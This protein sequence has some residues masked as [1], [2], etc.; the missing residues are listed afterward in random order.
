MMMIMIMIM[1]MAM[2]MIMIMIMNGHLVDDVRANLNN[3]K[4]LILLRLQPSGPRPQAPGLRPQ[5]SGLGPRASGFRPHDY[6]Y[7]DF[8]LSL[9]YLI[10]L[11]GGG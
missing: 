4:T 7:D 5:S 11:Q 2:I 9:F 10:L 8:D 1:T 3:K 6:E